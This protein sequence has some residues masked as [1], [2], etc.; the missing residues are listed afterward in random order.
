[1]LTI[2][3]SNKP[4][5]IKSDYH[6]GNLSNELKKTAINIIATQGIS[7]I[8]LRDLAIKCGV[9]AT[10]YRHYKNKEHLLAVIAE[11]GFTKLHQTMLATQESNKLQKIGIAYIHFAL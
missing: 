2:S 7:K 10:V 9:S 1:M 3:T 5:A 11:E 6:D 4:L 8:N